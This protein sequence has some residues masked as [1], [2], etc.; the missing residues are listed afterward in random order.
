LNV[1]FI[2]R[3]SFWVCFAIALTVFLFGAESLT[4]N[5]FTIDRA[6]ISSYLVIPILIL[7]AHVFERN[8]NGVAYL[9]SCIELTCFKFAATYMIATCFWIYAGDPPPL[10]QLKMPPPRPKIPLKPTQIPKQ[11]TGVLQGQILSANGRS[12]ADAVVYVR[13]GLDAFV[14]PIPTTTLTIRHDGHTFSPAVTLLQTHQALRAHSDDEQLHTFLDSYPVLPLNR[15]DQSGPSFPAVVRIANP[16]GIRAL[17]CG[18]HPNEN[19]D[20]PGAYLA[21]FAHPFVTSVDVQGRFRFEDLPRGEMEIEAW[22]PIH[23][24]ARTKI[25]VHPQTVTSTVMRLNLP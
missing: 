13:S 11:E 19:L 1:S 23:G 24:M 10:P 8:T 25:V 7:L 4:K 20:S 5:P 15:R 2:S 3:R 14:F 6:I 21:V 17:S 18:V 12:N 22:T 16:I 9:I